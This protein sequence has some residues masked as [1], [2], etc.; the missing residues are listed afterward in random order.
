MPAA[1][2]HDRCSTPSP[3]SGAIG[4]VRIAPDLES[5]G[6]FLGT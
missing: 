3:S 1:A 5:W 2:V 6:L 4:H